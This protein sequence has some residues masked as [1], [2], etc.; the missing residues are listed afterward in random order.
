MLINNY[1]ENVNVY[2]LFLL[3]FGLKYSREGYL[4]IKQ[5]TQKSKQNLEEK[6]QMQKDEFWEALGCHCILS[7]LSCCLQ[8]QPI[9]DKAY[10][11]KP[12]SFCRRGV[13]MC[14]HLH[15]VVQVNKCIFSAYVFKKG[16]PQRMYFCT[17]S[18][19][20]LISYCLVKMKSEQRSFLTLLRAT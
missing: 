19:S 9:F 3:C 8:L 18:P 12:I 2:S 5:I 14:C 13:L 17:P 20:S 4:P 1:L 11:E 15:L 16:I 7:L 10:N 6:A